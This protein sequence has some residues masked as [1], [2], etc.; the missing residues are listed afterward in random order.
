MTE[1]MGP[2]ESDCPA[3]ILDELTETDST[4]ASEWRS[5]CRANLF[6]RKLE[7]AKPVPKPGQTIVFDEPIRFNDGEDRNRFPVIAKS[8]G[9]TPL[10][11]A[12]IPGALCRNAQFRQHPY[13]RLTPAI[14][15]Q[16]QTTCVTS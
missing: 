11:R 5:R 7:R 3:A 16:E 13:R 2:C 4:Y 8:K 14:V 9:K 15:P 6:R 10:F 12:P 1:T